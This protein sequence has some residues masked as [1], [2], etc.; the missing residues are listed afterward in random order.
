L[1]AKLKEGRKLPE[2]Q[3]DTSAATASEGSKKRRRFK[4]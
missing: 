1:V 3:I 2:F 4:R